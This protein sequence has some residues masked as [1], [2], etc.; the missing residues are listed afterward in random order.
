MYDGVEHII[1]KGDTCLARHC[2]QTLFRKKCAAADK[3]FTAMKQACIISHSTGSPWAVPLHMVK[4]SGLDEW[5]PCG[6][7]RQ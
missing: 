7:Y 5:R 2:A 6:D 1:K 3:E 4:K